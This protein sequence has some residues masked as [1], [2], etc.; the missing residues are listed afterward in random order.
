MIFLQ[1]NDWWAVNYNASGAPLLPALPAFLALIGIAI[2]IWRWHRAESLL[3]IGGV[4]VFSL[5]SALSIE[6]K[7]AFRLIGTLPLLALLAGQGL[8]YFLEFLARVIELFGRTLRDQGDQT[9][10][11]ART[12]LL[13]ASLVT[14]PIQL[15]TTHF[16]FQ[17][18]FADPAAHPDLRVEEL[19][20]KFFI[21]S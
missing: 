1:G 14:M 5:P 15:A 12:V 13:V 16:T 9:L 19:Y 20:N 21:E 17:R 7:T 11:A 8:A 18:L 10:S 2:A 6:P 4:L 3:L